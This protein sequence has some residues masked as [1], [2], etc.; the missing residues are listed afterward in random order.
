MSRINDDGAQLAMPA[1]LGVV[2]QHSERSKYAGGKKSLRVRVVQ[3]LGAYATR[4]NVVR[5]SVLCDTVR[6]KGHKMFMH[7]WLWAVGTVM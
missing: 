7:R 1:T 3:I 2:M 6:E 5:R 4:R